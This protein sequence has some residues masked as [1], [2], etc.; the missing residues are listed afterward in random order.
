LWP[1]RVV[2]STDADI[3]FYCVITQDER[4]PEMQM[5]I[6]KYVGDVK[7]GMYQDIS[8]DE[9]YKRTLF[10]VNLT[11]QA[12]KERS[13]QQVFDK[14]GVEDKTRETVME[15]FFRS[16]PSKLSD[17]GYWKGNFY[18]KDVKLEEF[19][20]AQMVNRIKI[21]FRK[22]KELEA[23]FDYGASD[24]LFTFSAAGRVFVVKYKIFDHGTKEQEKELRIRKLQELLRIASETVYGYDFKDFDFV[25][26]EDQL[27]NS[28]FWAK[29]EDVYDF[30]KKKLSVENV[31][32][33]G[34]NYF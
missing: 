14:L 8:R 11:P 19:L 20:A 4:L 21:D 30:N 15:E 28:A 7:R 27:T 22:E 12:Q 3:Q 23:L 13:I 6:I 25:Q 16:P 2:L 26:F 9:S 34:P 29:A 1:R 10:S 33:Q 24:S 18:I 31:I 32:R 17:I 5:V